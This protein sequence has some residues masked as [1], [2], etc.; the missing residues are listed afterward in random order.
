MELNLCRTVVSKQKLQQMKAVI[1]IVGLVFAGVIGFG[2]MRVGRPS[3]VEGPAGPGYRFPWGQAG[4]TER[5]AAA[6]LISR[7]TYGATPG[8]VDEVAQMGL[9]K[10]FARQL[11]AQLPDDS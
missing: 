10:W 7:L 4:L 5:Q 6:H 9:E 2:G 11:E 3:P 1:G 8:E